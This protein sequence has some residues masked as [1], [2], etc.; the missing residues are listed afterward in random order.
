MIRR[1][2][3][4][5]ANGI[6]QPLPGANIHEQPR[7][8][9]SAK[10]LVHDFKRVIVRVAAINAEINHLNF[11][12]IDVIFFYEINSWPGSRKGDLRGNKLFSTRHA[13]ESLAQLLFH[14]R[15]IKV[16]GDAKNHIGWPN[17]AFVP[18]E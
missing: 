3:Y 10:Q 4:T 2:A 12:L 1:C 5:S 8:K 7:G 9:S 16:A 11:A 6:C 14:C 13:S 15:R 18:L 17:R